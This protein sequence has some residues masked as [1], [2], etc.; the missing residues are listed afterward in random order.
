MEIHMT[1]EQYLDLLIRARRHL[2][3]V[4]K[5]RSVDSTTIGDKYTETNVGLCNEEL[6]TEETAMWPDEFPARKSMKYLRN[7]H[8]CP[9]DWREVSEDNFNGCFYTCRV[10]HSGLRDVE[11]MKQ[12]FDMRIAEVQKEMGHE[13]RQGW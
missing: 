6:T 9:L 3:T 8:H 1:D 11:K 4:G 7:H 2:D 5:V 12:A 13:D 10:F